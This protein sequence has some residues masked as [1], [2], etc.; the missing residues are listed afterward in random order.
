MFA[1]LVVN[2]DVGLVTTSDMHFI[3]SS[4]KRG[5]F[6]FIIFKSLLLPLLLQGGIA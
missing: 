5:R 6:Y 1:M 3:P 4:M 2:E